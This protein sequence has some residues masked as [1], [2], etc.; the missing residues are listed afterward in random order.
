MTIDEPDRLSRSAIVAQTL[1][2][3]IRIA[4]AVTPIGAKCAREP[5]DILLPTVSDR[6]GYLC[7]AIP[8]YELLSFSEGA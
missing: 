4:A 1:P 3:R 6:F 2:S 5:S 8:A 7:G